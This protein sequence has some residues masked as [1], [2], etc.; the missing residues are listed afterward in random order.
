MV[1]HVAASAQQAGYR[2]LSA[3]KLSCA[4]VPSP[5]AAVFFVM[6]FKN[7]IV[8]YKIKDYITWVSILC[9]KRAFYSR[10]FVSGFIFVY[11]FT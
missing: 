10:R 1:L 3:V 4:T 2:A 8:E 6:V 9:R 11:M 7:E 5:E